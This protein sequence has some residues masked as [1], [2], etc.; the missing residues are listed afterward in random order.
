[1][2]AFGGGSTGAHFPCRGTAGANLQGTLDQR[3][4]RPG[5][6]STAGRGNR[7]RFR[8]KGGRIARFS[9]GAREVHSSRRHRSISPTAAGFGGSGRAAHMQSNG[10]GGEAHLAGVGAQTSHDLS[11]SA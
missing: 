2:A 6:C 10:V 9:A 7:G 3:Q 8:H 11:P 1:M 5:C 4:S